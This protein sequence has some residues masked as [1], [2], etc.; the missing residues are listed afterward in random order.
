MTDGPQGAFASTPEGK[1]QIPIYP[2]PAP[3]VDRTGAGDAFAATFVTAL[4]KCRPPAEALRWAAVNAM[5]VL[6]HVGSRR[7]LL[8]QAGLRRWL[9]AA[10]PSYCVR[11]L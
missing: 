11:P 1:F 2:D 8:D 6:Q 10:P 3:P 5:S 9:E 4:I 7:G